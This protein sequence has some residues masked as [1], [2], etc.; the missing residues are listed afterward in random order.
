MTL[1]TYALCHHLGV[2]IRFVTERQLLRTPNMLRNVSI[3]L[4]PSVVNVND[5]TVDIFRQLTQTSNPPLLVRTGNGSTWDTFFARDWLDRPRASGDVAFLT[6]WPNVSIDY[7][8]APTLLALEQLLQPSLPTG[9]VGCV[10]PGTTQAVLGVY[11]AASPDNS[12]V[13]MI[14]LLQKVAEVEVRLPTTGTLRNAWDRTPVASPISLT[15]LETLVLEV[16]Y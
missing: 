15:S 14:N 12:H 9:V 5:T 10:L 16:V 3:V 13:V 8:D 11:C 7:A 6:Q 4:V 2:K 1:A